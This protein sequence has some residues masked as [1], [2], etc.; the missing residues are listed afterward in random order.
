MV[1]AHRAAQLYRSGLTLAQVAAELGC[2]RSAVFR[3]L[4]RDGVPRRSGTPPPHPAATADIV[5]LR[6]S[7]LT[8]SQV[9]RLVGMTDQGVRSRYTTATRGRV[10]RAPGAQ[11]RLRQ[12]QDRRWA[13]LWAA[14]RVYYEQHGRWPTLT[15]EPVLSRWMRAQQRQHSAGKLSAAREHVLVDEGFPFAAPREPSQGQA[16]RSSS[17]PSTGSSAPTDGK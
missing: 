14:V 6:D 13:E 8:W 11:A 15:T 16:T 17:A 10:R 12:A 4:R 9:A 7:G 2:S 3:R 1:D 5:R